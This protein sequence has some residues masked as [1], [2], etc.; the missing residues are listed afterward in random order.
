M[1]VSTDRTSQHPTGTDTGA[2]ARTRTRNVVITVVS[3]AVALGFAAVVAVPAAKD[4][5]Q[6]RHDQAASYSSGKEAKADRASVP[7]WL[8]DGA[9]R[10]EY[11]MKTTG[12]DRL[13]KA[14]LPSSALPADC[15]PHQAAATPNPPAIK[16]SWFPRNAERR[17]SARCGLHYAYMEGNTLYAW[18]ANDDWIAANRA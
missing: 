1:S 15:K 17:T 13:L 4:W 14:A 3:V 9:K 7:R 16:A 8:P 18:Q 5:F 11:A 6:N 12:G 2:R 10:V